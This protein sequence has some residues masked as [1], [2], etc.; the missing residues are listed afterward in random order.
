MDQAREDVAKPPPPVSA[1]I[2]QRLPAVR[3]QQEQLKPRFLKPAW[4][5]AYC[6]HYTALRDTCLVLESGGTARFYYLLY[7]SVSPLFSAFLNVV[8]QEVSWSPGFDFDT[9]QWSGSFLADVKH[10]CVGIDQL[11]LAPWS[12]LYVLTNVF[13]F[14][15]WVE[16]CYRW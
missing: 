16:P 12:K 10:T 4:L 13:F 15:W 6:H 3:Q 14:F 7:S 2:S 1:L 11:P 9:H 5:S 8:E